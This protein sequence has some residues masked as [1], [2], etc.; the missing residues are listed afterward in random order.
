MDDIKGLTA[1]VS[2]RKRGKRR[3]FWEYSEQLTPSKQERMLKPSEWD[4]HTLPSNLYQKNGPLHGKHT[5]T[6]HLWALHR[7]K[8]K[9]EL[10]MWQTREYLPAIRSL[11]EPLEGKL[12]LIEITLNFFTSITC[13]W[14]CNPWTECV[15]RA[16]MI[17][18]CHSSSCAQHVAEIEQF[19]WSHWEYQINKWSVSH[20]SH[21]QPLEK[22]Q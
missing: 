18:V 4:R 11:R 19:K 6:L 17:R 21:K 7:S 14:D 15:T 12:D 5:Y 3:Y 22:K 9:H 8:Y 20:L 13:F 1:G 16:V 10:N 2:S